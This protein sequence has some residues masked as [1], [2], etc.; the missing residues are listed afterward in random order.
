MSRPN[1][2]EV[3]RYY[4]EQFRSHY[5][6]PEGELV[7]TDKPDVI[8][9]GSTAIGVEIANL[10]I[11]SGADPAGEQVQRI[12]RQQTLA[13]A[14]ALHL[15]AGGRRIELSVDFQP[16]QPILEVESVARALAELAKRIDSSPSGQVSP[17]LFKHIPQLR[18]VYNNARQYADAQ[19]RSVQCYC[20]PS[21]SVERLHEVVQEKNQKAKAYQPCDVYWLLLV[22]DFMDPAQD[23]EL[24]W[25]AEARLGESPFERILLYKPQFAQVVEVAK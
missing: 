1:N 20:L 2:Q 15:A 9:R 25:P 22:V 4:F 10:Y 24:W 6:M 18:F 12:R 17:T 5:P 23:Q 19:W 7:Y 8:T 16:N 11:V 13:R 21:L 14:Q 3:E